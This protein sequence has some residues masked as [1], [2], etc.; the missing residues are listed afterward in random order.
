[1]P[2]T[3]ILIIILFIAVLINLGLALANLFRKEGRESTMAKSLTWRVGISIALFA[4]I[5][6]LIGLGDMGVNP[7]PLK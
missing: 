3:K 2:F 4:M 5:V 7:S 6:I 1:M